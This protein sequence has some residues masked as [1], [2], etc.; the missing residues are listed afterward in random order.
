MKKGG[1][2]AEG[3]HEIT[4]FPLNHILLY[5]FTFK[6]RVEMIMKIKY[7]YRKLTSIWNQNTGCLEKSQ[8]SRYLGN[9]AWGQFKMG[10]A[11]C[12]V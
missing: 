3:T 11:V 10:F 2:T 8:S 4:I 7:K 12:C 5:L 1:K 6:R 9:A